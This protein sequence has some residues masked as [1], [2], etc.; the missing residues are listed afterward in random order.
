MR[1]IFIVMFLVSF[2]S[3]CMGYENKV[4]VCEM[5]NY[6]H[7]YQSWY[8]D[9]EDGVIKRSPE[10]FVFRLKKKQNYFWT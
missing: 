1:S 9:E 6:I 3:E 4:F 7:M 2:G 10:K 5:T 8:G